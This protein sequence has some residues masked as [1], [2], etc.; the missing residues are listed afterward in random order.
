LIQ[1]GSETEVQGNGL[2][3]PSSF[4]LFSSGAPRKLGGSSEL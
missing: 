2:S 1:A 4:P 3:A